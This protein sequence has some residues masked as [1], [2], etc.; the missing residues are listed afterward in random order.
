MLSSKTGEGEIMDF[1]SN[2]EPDGMP[3][4]GP[5]KS[6]LRLR[7]SLNNRQDNDMYNHM[8]NGMYYYL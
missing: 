5:F 1:I 8:N 2:T 3:A 4:C 7:L 6:L